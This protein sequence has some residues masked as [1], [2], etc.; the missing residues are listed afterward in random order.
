MLLAPPSDPPPPPPGGYWST[1]EQRSRRGAPPGGDDELTVGSV[2]FSLGLLRVGA[3]AVTLWMAQTP[4]RCPARDPAGCR[5][6]AIYG[7][8]G[9][10]EGGLMVGTGLTYLIIGAVRRERYR[11]W[12]AGERVSLPR[13]AIETIQLE[14]G[15]WMLR[16]PTP[17]SLAPAGGGAQ[18][19]IRF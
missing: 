8:L 12:S 11:R 13:P 4:S 10:G 19:R 18:L 7:W 15:P 16:A 6:Y 17:G 14:L 2:L 5:G 1:A 9:V 3:A